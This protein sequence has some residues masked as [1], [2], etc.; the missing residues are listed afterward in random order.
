MAIKEK[1]RSLRKTVQQASHA[2]RNWQAVQRGTQPGA[3]FFQP[4]LRFLLQVDE[5]WLQQTAA[6]YRGCMA[7]WQHLSGLKSASRQ[8]DGV[9]KSL[10]VAEGL[11]LWATVKHFRPRVVVELGTQHGVS[12]RLWKEAL[13]KYVPDHEL[14]LCDIEDVRRLIGDSEATFLL[15][16]ARQT[17]QQVFATR[18]V[19]LLFNDAHPYDL[20][21]W[22]VEEGLKHAVPVFAFH[23][24]GR[25]HSRNT[26]KVESASVP[27][28][29]RYVESENWATYGAWERHVMG[30]V[31]DQR[32]LTQDAVEMPTARMQVFDSLFGLGIVAARYDTDDHQGLQP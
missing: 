28:T 15:G 1:L 14:I 17:L 3:I 11:A 6:E 18:K 30:E 10:D 5:T 2:A 4:E 29:K 19:D 16:D 24:V 8:T 22:S 20:I 9:A 12:A 27:L 26:F 32:I 25:H 21:R 13:K 31:F 7:A 23:D